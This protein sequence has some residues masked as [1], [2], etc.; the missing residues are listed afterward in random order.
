MKKRLGIYLL[1]VCFVSGF[2]GC[3][4]YPNYVE[5]LRDNEVVVD[6]WERGKRAQKRKEYEIAKQEYYF[7]KRFATTYYLQVWAQER[8]EKMSRILEERG[9]ED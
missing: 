7:V 8:Y 4:I 1:L 9:E 5:R 2:F 6:A 3:A